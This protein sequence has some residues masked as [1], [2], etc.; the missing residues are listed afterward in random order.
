MITVSNR[1]VPL[2]L[3]ALAVTL[4]LAACGSSRG[5]ATTTATAAATTK[6]QQ[7][8]GDVSA[9]LA[10]G[11]DPDADPVGYAEAQIEPLRQI[12]TANSTLGNAIT[13][14]AND[15]SSYY[16]ANGKG[17]SVKSAL[18]AAINKINALCPGAGAT[19]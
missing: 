6:A 14:L 5:P 3:T 8:C 4:P 19:T 15:Y 17:D 11:P 12:H 10:D 13:A 2:A 7:T 16:T 9:V 1:V 18:N